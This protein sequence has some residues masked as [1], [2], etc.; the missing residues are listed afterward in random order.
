MHTFILDFGAQTFEKAVERVLAGAVARSSQKRRVAGMAGGN[1]D[2]AFT[3]NE[4]SY[5]RFGDVK[6]SKK[7]N[8]HYFPVDRDFSFRKGAALRNAGIVYEYIYAAESFDIGV[9][10]LNA[11]LFLA[12]ITGKSRGFDA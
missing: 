7:I 2:D 1:N 9:Y 4:V 3:I 11:L 5:C 8:V 10:G 6:R 12:D